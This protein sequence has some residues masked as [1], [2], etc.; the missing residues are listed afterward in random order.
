MAYLR[1]IGFDNIVTRN[2]NIKKRPAYCAEDYTRF[3]WFDKD[4]RLMVKMET[5]EAIEAAITQLD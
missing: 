2:P 4:D 1:V 5:I 3:P